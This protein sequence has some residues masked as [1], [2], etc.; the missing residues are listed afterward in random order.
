MDAIVAKGSLNLLTC[1][2]SRALS[3]WLCVN[4]CA[5]CPWATSARVD[6]QPTSCSAIILGHHYS[7]I[8]NAAS[9]KVS[10]AGDCVEGLGKS[11]YMHCVVTLNEVQV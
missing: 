7:R 4:G 1:L 5:Q 8:T 11:A 3:F 9:G 10:G 6:Q 2:T